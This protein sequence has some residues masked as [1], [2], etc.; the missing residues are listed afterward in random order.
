MSGLTAGQEAALTQVLEL[1]EDCDREVA[2]SVLS[3]VD[4]D[5]Q[6]QWNINTFFGHDD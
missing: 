3:S 2:I 1:A 6:V 4:W 5:V